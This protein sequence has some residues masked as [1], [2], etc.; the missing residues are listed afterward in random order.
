MNQRAQELHLADSSSHPTAKPHPRR[1]YC[2]HPL[3]GSTYT[4]LQRRNEEL[5]PVA[6]QRLTLPLS[7][8]A[9]WLEEVS[10]TLVS[11]TGR[12]S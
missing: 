12:V 1:N 2:V 4:G 8:L 11:D 6:G 9:R 3:A 5:A 7:H 10:D